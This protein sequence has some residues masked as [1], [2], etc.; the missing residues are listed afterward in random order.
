[1]DENVKHSLANH[2]SCFLVN[3]AGC[4]MASKTLVHLTLVSFIPGRTNAFHIA[5]AG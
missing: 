4:S 3:K 2:I 5:A 1:M